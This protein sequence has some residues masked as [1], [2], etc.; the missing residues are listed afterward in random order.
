MPGFIQVENDISTLLKHGEDYADTA[1][2]LISNSNGSLAEIRDF[3]GR[4]DQGL[5]KDSER[6]MS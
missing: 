6:L 5:D 1:I 2:R 3:V 4:M